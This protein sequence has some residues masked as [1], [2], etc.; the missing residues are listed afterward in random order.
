MVEETQKKP[1]SKASVYRAAELDSKVKVQTQHKRLF[2][3]RSSFNG[4]TA[5]VFGA[6]GFVA[7]N[8]IARLGK[9][10]SQIV[11]A[12]RGSLYEVEKNRVA[13]DLG[14]MYYSHFFLK[15]EKSIHEALRY[16]NVVINLIGKESETRNFSFDEVHVEGARRLARI[17]REAGVRKFI[18]FS[19]LNANPNPT[20]I[21]LKNGS[22]FLRSK[23]YGELAVRE[24]FPDAVIIRPADI[25]GEQDRFLNHY[26]SFQRGLFSRKM[27]LWDY[28][29][30]VEKQP[31]FVRNVVDGVEKAIFDGSANGE[32]IQAVGPHRY[33][34]EDLI[35]YIRACSGRGQKY[36]NCEITNLRWNLP[37]RIAIS[38]VEKFQKYPFMTW[39]RVE[40]DSTSDYVSPN[41]P[42]LTDFGVELDSVER[43]I[44]HLGY[45]RPRDHRV[46]VPYESALHID[47]PARLS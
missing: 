39:E 16:S 30:G 34:F 15:D 41:L 33:K 45:Y 8:L 19:S 23:Y 2:P 24:E 5:T 27:P 11:L 35:E 10:G 12:Y 28:Y 43:H 21:C 14:H 47:L 17:A 26:T 44:Q 31:I 20:P 3:A 22:Q 1:P 9:I 7:R 42:T 4:I 36:D 32:I 13:A 46:E 38:M 37:M 6:S 40:R 29:D 25:I 18:H